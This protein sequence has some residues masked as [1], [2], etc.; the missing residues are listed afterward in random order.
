MVSPL[1]LLY[2]LAGKSEG[3]FRRAGN[4]G[5]DNRTIGESNVLDLSV[6]HIMDR[7]SLA[8]FPIAFE[9]NYPFHGCSC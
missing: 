6:G 5:P 9:V 3:A 4:P 7:R 8:V 1:S 2:L